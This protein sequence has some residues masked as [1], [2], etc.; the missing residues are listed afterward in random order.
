MRSLALVM[1]SLVASMIRER[2][3]VR[4]A[5]YTFFVKKG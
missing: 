4:W 1:V 5:L 2:G 3:V